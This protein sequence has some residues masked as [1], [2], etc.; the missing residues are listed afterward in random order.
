MREMREMRGTYTEIKAQLAR[1]PKKQL[2]AMVLDQEYNDCLGAWAD[3]DDSPRGKR[4]PYLGWYWRNVEFSRGS[5]TLGDSGDVVGFMEKNKWG[6]PER[7]TTKEEFARAIALIDEARAID[8]QGGIVSEI[9][10]AR[11]VKLKE[12]YDYL[13][14]LKHEGTW[15]DNY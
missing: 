13:Q 9:H 5:F 12:L 8:G 1:V 4:I 3:D 6:Y 11:D 14:S 7:T 15:S 2:E 10:A